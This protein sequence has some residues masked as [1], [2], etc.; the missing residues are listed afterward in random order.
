M[1]MVRWPRKWQLS[2]K[3]FLFDSWENYYRE[4]V[5]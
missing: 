3:Y 2:C 5:P 4:R 1:S